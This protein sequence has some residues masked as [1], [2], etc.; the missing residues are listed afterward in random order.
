[1]RIISPF[2]DY[3]DCVQGQGQDLSLLYLRQPREVQLQEPLFPF[4]TKMC[5][6][7]RSA[8][9][10]HTCYVVG[11][12]GK[13]HSVLGVQSPSDYTT[14]LM[15]CYALDEVDTF[16]HKTFKAKLAERY[17]ADAR[18]NYWRETWHY[19]RRS[20]LEAFFNESLA[21]RDKYEHI[22]RDNHCPV[23]VYRETR[24]KY[25]LT[26]NGSLRT[27]QFYRCVEPFTAFQEIQMFLGG[28]A[29]PNKPIPEV[30]D[31]IMAAAKG[32]DKWS[33]RKEPKKCTP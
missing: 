25:V 6:W 8:D 19:T 5:H 3:Y 21:S 13:I 18:R 23:F 11:F 4:I 14:P 29:F 22:F 7:R 32:F 27:L 10:I 24:N 26:Y 20:T 9:L 15:L 31:K 28:M 16:V 30:S 17:F 12:C 33:F 2:H 1:M